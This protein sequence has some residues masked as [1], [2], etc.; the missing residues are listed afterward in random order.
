MSDM[1][2]IVTAKKLRNRT[3]FKREAGVFTYLNRE[4]PVLRKE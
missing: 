1:L 3:G 4:D 2:A